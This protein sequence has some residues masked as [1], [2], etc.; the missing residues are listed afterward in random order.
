MSDARDHAALMAA[1]GLRPDAPLLRLNAPL[2]ARLG[3]AA[4]RR[5]QD[6]AADLLAEAARLRAGGLLH[7]ALDLAPDETLPTAFVVAAGSAGSAWD[8]EPRRDGTPAPGLRR[9]RLCCRASPLRIDWRASLAARILGRPGATVLTGGTPV[10]AC[11]AHDPGLRRALG[12]EGLDRL[13]AAGPALDPSRLLWCETRLPATL[14]GRLARLSG[15]RLQPMGLPPGRAVLVAAGDPSGLVLA[16]DRDVLAD[17]YRAG[18]EVA[19]LLALPAALELGRLLRG[20]GLL[21]LAALAPGVAE[22]AGTSGP[23]AR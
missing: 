4:L 17:A 21:A 13:H 12:P 7:L 23:V 20:E 1:H 15:L 22:E 16:G 18:A 6:A 11:R 19:A 9:A 3:R 5:P 2:E 10:T 8:P 14:L